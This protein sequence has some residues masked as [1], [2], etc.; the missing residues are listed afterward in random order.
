MTAQAF[1]QLNDA[2]VRAQFGAALLS[3]RKARYLS[4]D[5]VAS[6]LNILPCHVRLIENAEYNPVAQRGMFVELV[7]QYC[8][9]ADVEIEESAVASNSRSSVDNVRLTSTGLPLSRIPLHSAAALLAGVLVVA[10]F[11]PLSQMADN[12]VS[13]LERSQL[14]PSAFEQT[15][16]AKENAVYKTEPAVIEL[17]EIEPAL[18]EQAAIAA[19]QQ[20]LAMVAGVAQHRDDTDLESPLGKQAMASLE[21]EPPTYPVTENVDNAD[22]AVEEVSSFIAN[23]R[24]LASRS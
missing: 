8:Q 7:Q 16:G 19:P 6:A 18:T 17:A 2:D 4:I 23:L 14:G 5:D 15:L 12:T 9:F 20:A 22:L 3:A 10:T 1:D 11:L 24:L 13:V 21:E